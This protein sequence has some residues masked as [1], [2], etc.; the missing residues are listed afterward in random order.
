[1]RSAALDRARLYVPGN[2]QAFGIR[3]IAQASQFFDGDVVTLALLHPGVREIAQH[4]QNEDSCA[5]KFQ[6][7]AGFARHKYF[8]RG[9]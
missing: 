1:M 4:Q 9:L 2:P 6:V 5:T 7:F 8:P 3:T